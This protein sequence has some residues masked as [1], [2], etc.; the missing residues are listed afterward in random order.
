VTLD[1]G[2]YLGIQSVIPDIPRASSR[3]IYTGWEK[4]A[5]KELTWADYMNGVLDGTIVKGHFWKAFYAG[6]EKVYT[7]EGYDG[8]GDPTEEMVIN[9]IIPY[10]VYIP[11]DYDPA[12]PS[13]LNFMLHGGTGNE[14]APFER[15]S[16]RNLDIEPIADEHGY[17]VLSPNGWTRSPAWFK[18]PA[19]YSF[20]KSFEM[21]CRDYNIDRNKLF[22]SGNSAGGK[23]TWDLAIRYPEMFVAISPQAP[24][25]TRE[26]ISDEEKALFTKK[27]GNKPAFFIHG[28]ADATIPYYSRYVPWA[29]KWVRN[30]FSNAYFMTIEAGNHSYAYGSGM[31]AMYTFFDSILKTEV[32]S[33][34]FKMLTLPGEGTEALLD[35][36]PY[37]LKYPMMSSGEVAM[38][39]L[40][41]L[42]TL[43]GPDFRVYRVAAYDTDPQK[44]V[45][46]VTI[47]HNGHSLNVKMGETFLR[48]D[49]ELYIDDIPEDKADETYVDGSPVKNYVV[50]TRKL[51]VAPIEAGGQIYVPAVEIIEL[52]DRTVVVGKKG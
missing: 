11:R 18:G 39:S 15:E 23:G 1:E 30:M 47:L 37:S 29:A 49:A 41:D 28:T 3:N 32:P 24:A 45:H 6:T 33:H 13:K 27:I 40:T 8:E 21:V 10:N 4:I 51:S 12:T 46:V 9:R 52:L 48:V 2:A 43:Y 26:V 19:R 14:N 31:E 16:D 42:E 20:F 50:P 34:S 44:P 25:S 38:I 35:E 5:G 22:L 17:I 7:G 36:K